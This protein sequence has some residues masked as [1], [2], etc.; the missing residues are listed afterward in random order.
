MSLTRFFTS[1]Y[2]S[3]SLQIR[4]KAGILTWTA[5]I[6]GGL[7][8][9]LG[10]VM[11]M[12]GAWVAGIMIMIFAAVCA[13]VLVLLKLGK[14]SWASS[15]FLLTLYLVMFL[16]IKFDTYQDIYECYVFG[17]LAGFLLIAGALIGD[18]P[19][20]AIILM[21]LSLLAIAI[22]YLADSLPEELKNG[23]VSTLAIQ[24]L[25]T[26]GFL[27]TAGGIL[28]CLVIRT[29][30]SLLVQVE[31]EAKRACDNYREL[32]ET[33]ISTQD[34][35][36]NVGQSLAQSTDHTI[37]AIENM[38]KKVQEITVGMRSLSHA[39][40]KSEQS[41]TTAVSGQ[42]KV[43]EVLESYSRQVNTASSAIE[44]MAAA[45]Q[46]IG[47]QTNQKRDAVRTLSAMA[48]S[49][50]EKLTAIKEAIDQVLDSS[51]SMM[52]MSRIIGDVADRTNLLGL[53]ASIEAAHAGTVGKG[54]A[55][56][57][58]QIRKLSEEVATSSRVITDTLATTREAVG[59][60]SSENDEAIE[61]F[62]KISEDIQG[63]TLMME[64]FLSSIQE[65]S[66]G[67]N[68]VLKAVETVAALTQTT[69]QAVE[70]S[71]TSIGQSS[72]GIRSVVAI[73]E[74]VHK[75]A[76][77]INTTFGEIRSDAFSIKTLG[78]ESLGYI[79]DLKTR[80]EA[81]QQPEL[82]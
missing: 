69:E 30:T 50:E 29:Q 2:G 10:L 15:V 53:N 62:R 66:S 78:D 33:I 67:A 68:D 71:R 13:S 74:Q 23:G 56:V 24:S 51:N 54:F 70:E 38:Q 19:F 17:A 11:I 16:A 32:N 35:M 36:M 44:Q 39:L 45:I 61:F 58:D 43:R 48:H 52:D 28:S 55:I 65:I 5:L 21:F 20:Q 9:L 60:A 3:E 34:R 41:N 14:Y 42:E 27:V 72:D 47:S 26:S 79:E 31:R 81:M 76:E 4:K 80:I 73:G 49:G 1:R 57:A 40:S 12:T 22:L 18:R 8:T 6:I 63:V 46:N 7:S 25:V 82:E 75:E 64:E 59:K 37:Q 77:E